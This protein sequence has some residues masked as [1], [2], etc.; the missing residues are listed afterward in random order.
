M[1]LALLPYPRFRATDDN[2]LPLAGGF[3]YS[4]QATT[5]TP[6]ALLLSDGTTSAANPVVLDDQGEADIRLGTNAYKLTLKTS[7]GVEVW[8]VD[9][10]SSLAPT[11]LGGYSATVAQM[12]LTTDPGE[13]GSESLALSMSGELERL[14]YAHYDTKHAIDPTI[15]QWYETPYVAQVFNV[16]SYGALG[17]NVTN[18]RTAIQAAITAASVAGGTVYFPAGTYVVSGADTVSLPVPVSTADYQT[19]NETLH[20]Q[21]YVTSV[22]GLRFVGDGAVTLRSDYASGGNMFIFNSCRDL[23]WD[24][25][26]LQSVTVLDAAGI[27]TTAGM[28]ALAFTATLQDSE[29]ILIHNYR[30]Q[31]T[32]AAFYV[33]GDGA[34]TYR[35]RGLTLNNMLTVNC[36]YGLLFADNG[37]NVAFHGVRTVGGNR[38]YFCYGVKNHQGQIYIKDG[39]A[40]FNPVL[41]KA[42]DQNTEDIHLQVRLDRTTSSV[43]AQFASQHNVAAQPTPGKVRNISLDYNEQGHSGGGG[44]DFVY[45][46]D[47]VVQATAT[48][49]VF[50]NITLRGV[51]ENDITTQTVFS[52][53]GRVKL[54]IDNVVYIS[55]SPSILNAQGFYTHAVTNYTPVLRLG[56]STTGITYTTQS[57]SY[58][59]QGNL[60][61]GTL[62]VLLS[63]KGAQTG[64]VTLTLP[65][66]TSD[67]SSRVPVLTVLGL[68]NLNGLTGMLVAYASTN[69]TTVQVLQMGATGATAIADTELTNTSRLIISFVYA[70]K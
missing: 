42:Y 49:A 43:K 18:D 5:S 6:Q 31:A 13:L 44:V 45:Y 40:A 7:A 17:D 14:R 70:K 65:L 52:G 20:Y 24:G 48:A 10:V 28:N 1:T 16:K 46:Q 21:F 37:D 41:I 39:T 9:N 47:E 63:S 62:E 3:L 64:V 32:Y 8:T 67:Q 33:F 60:V 55:G 15:T 66:A 59:Q 57:G 4:Y 53:A 51:F 29:R 54:N 19:A 34:A 30:A 22:T 11:V 35:V 36:Y 12:K 69:S 58:W 23:V 50:D 26:T 2:G 61:W 56:G 38:A 27:P 25:I 68:S